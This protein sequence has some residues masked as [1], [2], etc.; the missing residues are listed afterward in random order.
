MAPRDVIKRNHG[1]AFISADSQ[2]RLI[3]EPI[4]PKCAFCKMFDLLLGPIDTG[5]FS[6]RP[7]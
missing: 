5:Y 2:E 4:G 7:K 1:L 3:H 6:D